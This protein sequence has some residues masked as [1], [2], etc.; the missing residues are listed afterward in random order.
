M[1]V[2][3]TELIE[4]LQKYRDEIGCNGETIASHSTKS[5]VDVCYDGSEDVYLYLSS[6]ELNYRPGCGCPDG[7]TIHVD[8]YVNE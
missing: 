5:R 1:E 4:I 8:G 3:L 7:I 6:I 2:T